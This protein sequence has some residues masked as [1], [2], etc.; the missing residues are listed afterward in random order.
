MAR[1]PYQ[2]DQT[3]ALLARTPQDG[4][5]GSKWPKMTHFGSFWAILASWDPKYQRIM[6]KPEPFWTPFGHMATGHMAKTGQNRLRP[7][8]ESRTSLIKPGPL[9]TGLARMAQNDPFWGKITLFHKCQKWPFWKNGV[10]GQ[11]TF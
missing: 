3:W 5:K 1:T 7:W 2:P 10:A 11:T 9:L 8:P 4:Q 6:T